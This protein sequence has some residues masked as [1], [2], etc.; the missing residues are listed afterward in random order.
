MYLC[1]SKKG[2]EKMKEK[3][4]NRPHSPLRGPRLPCHRVSTPA[5]R[6]SGQGRDAPVGP[7]LACA[8]PVSGFVL[9]MPASSSRVALGA[10]TPVAL[11]G[12]ISWK[13]QNERS[14]VPLS[15]TS[16]R[17]ESQPPASHRLPGKRDKTVGVGLWGT[18]CGDRHRPGKGHPVLVVFT[19]SLTLISRGLYIWPPPRLSP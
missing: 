2:G 5:L 9:W 12:E 6:E 7:S 1:V 8:S 11:R 15:E 16:L 4:G 3:G 10:P 13:C 18:Q 14:L 17:T 19:H